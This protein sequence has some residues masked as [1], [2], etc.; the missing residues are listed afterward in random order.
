M[1]ALQA[2][3]GPARYTTQSHG[4]PLK[5]LFQTDFAVRQE[6]VVD[7]TVNFREGFIIYKAG[8]CGPAVQ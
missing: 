3:L 5:A 7:C 4:M 2:L 6:A 8:W 1:R